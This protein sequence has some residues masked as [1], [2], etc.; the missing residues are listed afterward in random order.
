MNLINEDFCNLIPKNFMTENVSLFLYSLIKCVRPMNILEVGS[1]YSTLFISKSIDDIKNE[2]EIFDRQYMKDDCLDYIGE[3]YNPKFYVIDNG[4]SP[5]FIDT[6]SV[7][8]SQN[9][10]KHITFVNDDVDCFLDNNEIYDFIWLDFGS[11]EKYMFYVDAFFK[12]L[13]PGGF[14]IVHSTEGNLCGKLFSTELKLI[15]KHNHN[16]EM[17]TIV[18]PHKKIQASFTI[19]KKN[20]EYPVYGIYA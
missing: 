5:D 8:E 9:L 2:K 12:K 18:E 15:M 7:L 17:I 20:C 3:Y 19:I 1:G 4:S 14:I 13:K 16:F 11:G 10:T 6:F